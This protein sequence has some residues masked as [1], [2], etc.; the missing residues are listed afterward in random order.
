M[1]RVSCPEFVDYGP[2]V[3]GHRYNDCRPSTF[4]EGIVH[5]D[6]DV[7]GDVV[8]FR[9]HKVELAVFPLLDRQ[10]VVEED[11]CLYISI[12]VLGLE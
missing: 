11:G 1:G 6:P 10:V 8:V 2:I 12:E 4:S 9:D 5:L 7:H 3:E